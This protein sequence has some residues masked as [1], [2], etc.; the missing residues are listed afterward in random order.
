M[1]RT[2]IKREK[3]RL[4]PTLFHL[5]GT[6]LLVHGH[7]IQA[8]VHDVDPAVLGGQDKQWH[9]SLSGEDGGKY[10][11]SRRPSNANTNA[12]R[13]THTHKHTYIGLALCSYPAL[14]FVWRLSWSMD[15][16][17]HTHTHLFCLYI[18]WPLIRDDLLYKGRKSLCPPATPDLSLD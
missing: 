8:M 1:A 13:L 3:K 7:S 4:F 15:T 16:H 6:H 17:T 2:D 10:E 11:Q 5:W 12:L 9:Q 14:S 18:S